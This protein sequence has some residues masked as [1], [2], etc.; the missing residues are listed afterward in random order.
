VR[1]AVA[2]FAVLLAVA[3][4]CSRPPLGVSEGGTAGASASGGAGA[5]GAAGATAGVSGSGGQ[6]ACPA[7]AACNDDLRMSAL[8]G[9]C[10]LD[11]SGTYYCQC[12]DGFSIDMKTWRCRAGSVCDNAAKDDAWPFGLR[13][14]TKD[15]AS[16]PVTGCPDPGSAFALNQIITSAAAKNGC[17]IV[18]LLTVRIELAGGCPTLLEARTDYLPDLPQPFLSCLGKVLGSLRVGCAPGPGCALIE[19]DPAGP[20]P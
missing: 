13:F 7:P 8:A 2:V 11:P 10:A 9:T 3:A 20:I 16:R 17:P 1:V 15:C 19:N 5:A 6:L 12:N 14:D 4:G 18:D